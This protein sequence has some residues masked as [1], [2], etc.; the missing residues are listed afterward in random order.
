MPIPRFAPPRL[1]EVYVVAVLCST[2]AA[3]AWS[4]QP[5]T[6]PRDSVTVIP[7]PQYAAGWLHRVLFG[8]HHRDLWTTPIRVPVLDL[9]RFGGGLHAVG[10]LGGGQTVGLR[11]R[12]ADGNEYLFRPL[13]K[14]PAAALPRELRETLVAEI[15]RDQISSQHPVSTLITHPLLSG[16]GIPHPIPRLVILPDSPLLAAFRERFAGQAGI[17]ETFVT[18]AAA[19]ADT[20]ASTGR[21]FANLQADPGNDVDAR[22]YLAARLMDIVVGD[23]DRH[24]GQ[25]L[26]AGVPSARGGIRWTPIPLDRDMAFSRIDGFFPW[27]ARW[28][29]PQLVGFGADYPSPLHSTWQAKELDHRLVAPLPGEVWDST[30]Q[31]IQTLLTDSLLDEAI[32]A[33]P[34]ALRS[35]NGPTLQRQLRRRRE[36][37]PHHARA[38]YHMYAATV[39]VHLSDAAETAVARYE[40]DGTLTVAARAAGAGETY[41]RRFLPAET[42]EVRIYL[43]GGDDRLIVRDGGAPGVALRVLGGPGDDRLLDSSAARR[44]APVMF[45]DHEGT[46]AFVRGPRTTVDTGAPWKTF[47]EEQFVPPEPPEELRPMLPSYGRRWRPVLWTAGDGDIG[48]FLGGG[49][50]LEGYGFRREPYAYQLLVRGGVATGR[51]FRPRTNVRLTLPSLEPWMAGALDVLVSG[52]EVI[53]FHGFGNETPN[54]PEAFFDVQQELL[55]IVPML[56]FRRPGSDGPSFSVGVI[57]KLVR[58]DLTGQDTTTLITQLRPFGVG[59]LGQVGVQG[60]FR[61]DS[62]DVPSHARR[63]VLLEVAAETYPAILDIPRP[64]SRLRGSG[65]TYLTPVNGV[66]LALRAEAEKLFGTFPFYEAAFLGGGSSLRGFREQRFAGDAATLGSAELRLDLLSHR[67]FLPGRLGVYGLADGGRVWVDGDSPGS[68]HAAFGGGLWISMLSRAN[69]MSVGAAAG[70]EGLRIYARAGLAY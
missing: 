30:A 20:L 2:L 34:P 3:P 54:E 41:R 39:A 10:T 8:D 21:M 36:R 35:L 66:T 57:G 53:H 33:M 44:G 25:W 5:V 50:L 13:E 16:V 68:W 43:H 70:G 40:P 17:L 45:Y 19:A 9:G 47:H 15:F 28:Y 52:I 58:T 11:L 1:A 37:L 62:R 12:A 29:M 64:F 48:L 22:A 46:N 67:I 7:G 26:W 59:T 51:S 23:W 14:D 31:A 61:W 55:R 6:V 18:A 65:F 27:L 56:T 32:A 60:R 38:V 63:G 24:R 4:Q 69:T 49:F 42:R